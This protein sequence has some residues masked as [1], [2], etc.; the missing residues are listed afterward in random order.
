MEKMFNSVY[1]S[2]RDK[3]FLKKLEKPIKM[4]K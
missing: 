3:D 2:K 4:D 1:L